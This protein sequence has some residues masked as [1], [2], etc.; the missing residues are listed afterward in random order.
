MLTFE[1]K[2]MRGEIMSDPFFEETRKKKKAAHDIGEDL[3]AISID[4]LDE[5]ILLLKNEILRLEEEK[6]KKS[7]VKSA[8]NTLFKTR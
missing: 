6:S 3:S 7:A 8:A 5:R 4:E 1:L 2:L